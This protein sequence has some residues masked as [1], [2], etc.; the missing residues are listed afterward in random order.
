MYAQ[1]ATLPL[2]LLLILLAGSIHASAMICFLLPQLQ[3]PG[4]PCCAGSEQ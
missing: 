4:W 2:L 1:P 3:R